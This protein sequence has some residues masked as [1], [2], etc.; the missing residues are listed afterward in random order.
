LISFLGVGMAVL[1]LTLLLFFVG[2]RALLPKN[3]RVPAAAL[4]YNALLIVR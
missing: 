1:A 4:G 2:L 3:S